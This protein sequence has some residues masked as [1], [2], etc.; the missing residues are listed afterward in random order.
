MPRA[1]AAG[2]GVPYLMSVTEILFY[3]MQR[4]P[5]EAV[6]PTL[7]EAIG[8]AP[9]PQAAITRLDGMFEHMPS[10]INIF[11]LLEARPGLA[12]LLARILAHAPPLADELAR[13]P[14]LIDG[15]IDASAL[16]DVGDGEAQCLLVFGPIG[17]PGQPHA[18]AQILKCDADRPGDGAVGPAD[19]HV[20]AV[21]VGVDGLE[22]G[23]DGAVAALRRRQSNRRH[24]RPAAISSGAGAG[25]KPASDAVGRSGSAGATARFTPNPPIS[26]SRRPSGRARLSHRMPASLAPPSSTSFGHF[27]VSGASSGRWS[28]KTSA[29]ATARSAAAPA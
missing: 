6:L 2:P 21:A 26:Q 8:H 12:D 17:A 22:A 28:A 7:V 10:A 9:D 16:D 19:E 4:Q 23:K 20:V 14:A 29:S 13:R 27:S 11:R 15:L 3:H 18:R 1:G 24:I 5:L 25:P